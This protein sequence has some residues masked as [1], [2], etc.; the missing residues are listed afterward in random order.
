MHTQEI[1]RPTWAL[2]HAPLPAALYYISNHV[3]LMEK[4]VHV[5]E[6]KDRFFGIYSKICCIIHSIT[7]KNMMSS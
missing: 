3:Y 1:S 6:K 4:Q 5:S 7:S 2:I